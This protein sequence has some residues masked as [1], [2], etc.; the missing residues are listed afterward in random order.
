MPTTAT[1]SASR[2]AAIP[3]TNN[4]IDYAY[5]D[6]KNSMFTTR[7]GKFANV[8]WG[9]RE[10]VWA[11]SDVI[12]TSQAV[13]DFRTAIGSEYRYGVSARFSMD[14]NNLAIT[15]SNPNAAF[16]DLTAA[17]ATAASRTNNGVAIGAYYTG[18]FMNK[19][20]QPI[21]AY[22][23][24]P[25]DQNTDAVAPSTSSVKGSDT[26]WN[27]GLKSEVG[28]AVIEVE[29]KEWKKDNFSGL[30]A[31]GTTTDNS[32]K[33]K[34]VFANI[35]Y[36]MGEWTPM[37]YYVND[38]FTDMSLTTSVTTSAAATAN[39]FKKNTYA[40]GVLWKPFADTNFRY[41]AYYSNSKKTYDSASAVYSKLTSSQVVVGIKF[42]I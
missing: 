17:S 15:L 33:T 41:H 38:K 7:W 37:F 3:T 26:M 32:A 21:L 5:I 14:T 6:H 23:T 30:T 1:A 10:T 2:E 4:G 34:S 35:M 12:V 25:Q 11:A 9:G 36:P 16:S 13:A 22:T 20:I 42:D 18:S 28:G 27:A 40:V 8:E 31:A 29:Y 24:L 19:M 39:D